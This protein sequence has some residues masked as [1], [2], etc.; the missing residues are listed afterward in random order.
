MSAEL[1][2]RIPEEPE[3]RDGE[4]VLALVLLGITVEGGTWKKGCHPKRDLYVE[5]RKDFF[6]FF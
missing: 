1:R 4:H 3:L 2:S 6:F 5:V